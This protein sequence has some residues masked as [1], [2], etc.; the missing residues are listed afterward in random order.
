MTDAPSTG[1]RAV[2]EA[3]ECDPY[4]QSSY[5]RPV[6]TTVQQRTEGAPS[7]SEAEENAPSE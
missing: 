7:R 1:W 3:M 4:I 6:Q 5:N 2:Y